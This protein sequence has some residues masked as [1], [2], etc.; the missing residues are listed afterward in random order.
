MRAD[1]AFATAS[2]MDAADDN[3]PLSLHDRQVHVAQ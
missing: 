1:S 2:S 3:T